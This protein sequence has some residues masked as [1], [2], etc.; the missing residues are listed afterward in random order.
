MIY[1]ALGDGHLLAR[2]QLAP[3]P[4]HSEYADLEIDVVRLPRMAAHC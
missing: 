1:L 3:W 2:Y 4:L